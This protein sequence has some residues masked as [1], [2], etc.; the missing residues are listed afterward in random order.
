MSRFYQRTVCDSFSYCYHLPDC[1]LTIFSVYKSSRNWF[2]YIVLIL[3]QR[4]AKIIAFNNH[5]GFYSQATFPTAVHVCHESRQVVEAIYPCCFGS[6]L[7]PEKAR[8]NF[9]LNILYLKLQKKKSLIASRLQKGTTLACLHYFRMSKISDDLFI[10]GSQA[11]LFLRD[12][13]NVPRRL[14]LL[15]IKCTSTN[16][17]IS[18]ELTKKSC[19]SCTWRFNS[20]GR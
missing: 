17:A 7:V 14:W 13:S 2:R 11:M 5:A 10:Y 3:V 6:F 1:L 20:S 4:M 18:R 12:S 16:S 19:L 9:Y 15:Q 8:S